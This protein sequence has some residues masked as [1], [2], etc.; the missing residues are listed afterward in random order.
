MTERS[1]GLLITFL[2][3]LFVVPDSLFVRLIDSDPMT[4]AFWRG[5][6]G[7]SLI[8]LALIFSNGI[9]VFRPAMRS[10][11]PGI[12]YI[13]LIGSTTPAFVLAVTYTSVANVVFI[14]ASIPIFALIFSYI[15]LGEKIL[16][17]TLI[18]SL[19]VI[20]GLAIIAYG[21]KTSEIS[22]WKGDVWALYVSAAY[23]GALTALRKVKEI[24]MVP[25]VPIAFLGSSLII[26][27]FHYPFGD[28]DEKLIFYLLHGFFIG[29]ASWLL[30][31]GPRYLSS[32][33]VSLL[34]LLETV[35]APILVWLVIG[36]F[37]GHL[38]IIGGSL[39]IV[40]LFIFNLFKLLKENNSVY[41]Y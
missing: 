3:V 36:E 24:S 17:S 19:I 8:L 10:G 16:L 9:K 25:T 13:L 29:I 27:L 14:F 20:I 2:G 31:L 22:S 40:T 1:K 12:I 15:F 35:F 38:A 11:Y 41:K 28:L 37:P 39:I 4:T 7:G 6:I 21:S 32:P 30:T 5:L 18:T 26:F 34:I 23:A 33:E